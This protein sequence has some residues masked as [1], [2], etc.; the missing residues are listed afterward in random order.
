MQTVEQKSWQE[1]RS[2]GMLWF[3]NR[4][5][6][7]FGWSIIFVIEDN[8]EVSNVYPARVKYRGFDEE[9]ETENFINV[10]KFMAENAPELLKEAREE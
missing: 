9:V 4:I 7:V 6:H 5:L 3:V 8:G 2:A 10:S 1:F